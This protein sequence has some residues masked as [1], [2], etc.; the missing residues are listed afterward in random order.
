MSSRSSAILAALLLTACADSPELPVAVVT[1]Q[2]L[3]VEPGAL[4]LPPLSSAQLTVRAFDS[5]DA[6]VA[7]VARQWRSSDT[8]VVRVDSTGLVRAGS[9]S[10]TASISVT[11]GSIS[12]RIPVTVRASAVSAR[13][14]IL[15]TNMASVNDWSTAV[16]FVDLMKSSRRW[17]SNRAGAP[18]DGGGPLAVSAEGWIKRLDPGQT[19]VTLFFS[20]ELG[21]HP[22]GRYVVLYDGDGSMR[23]PLNSGVRVANTAAGRIELD[24]T[25]NLAAIYLE[26]TAVNEANPL[27]NIRVLLPGTE[28][29]YATQPFNAAYLRVLAPFSVLRFMDMQ[30][31]N[32]SPAREF[33]DL[34]RLSER[35]YAS[36]GGTPPDVMI[37][38]ANTVGAD[39]WF[40]MPHQ[41]SDALVI[42]FAQRTLQRLDRSR[43]VYV[44]YSN[45]TW[46]GQFQQATYVRQQGRTFGLSNDDFQAGLFYTARRSVEIFRIWR[47]VFGADSSRVIRVL[48]AQAAN[49]WTGDQELQFRDAFRETDALAIAPYFSTTVGLA[50]AA[51]AADVVAGLRAHINGGVRDW[52]SANMTV[53]QRYG[54]QLIAYEGGQHQTSYQVPSALEPQV[55]ALYRAVNRSADMGTLYAAYLDQWKALGGGLFMH[56]TDVARPSKFGFW[57]GLE[58]VWEPV[59]NA[60]KQQALIDFAARNRP[61]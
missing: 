28:S 30:Y 25:P 2:R 41:A 40:C 44:E 60:P 26:I 13:A 23:F 54:V 16:P 53:A 51:S 5:H 50:A 34:T 4:T 9:V 22:A 37:D 11:S 38:L 31:T 21:Q 43:K 20:D 45:E 52:I 17:V 18:W 8:L 46:N 15:G 61:P 7:G 3:V 1:V 49:A 58:S 27:R 14:A 10:D 29:T 6:V 33:G 36:A 59:T 56:F 55:T 57:G 12:A 42:A 32:D 19:A 48:S 39:P 47:Q 35:T 24:V